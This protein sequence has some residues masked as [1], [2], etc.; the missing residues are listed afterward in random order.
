MTRESAVQ[1]LG[2][3]RNY[4]MEDVKVAYKK[5]ARKYH[6]DIAGSEYT[7]KFAQ[8]NEAYEFIQSVGESL[9]CVLTHETIFNVKRV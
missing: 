3:S 8:I 7:D 5:L 1:I 4:T 9:G 2:L 6:P